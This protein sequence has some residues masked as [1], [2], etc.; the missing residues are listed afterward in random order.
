MD[1][2][3]DKKKYINRLNEGEIKAQF[4]YCLNEINY[5]LA[6]YEEKAKKLV[7]LSRDH[8]NFLRRQITQDGHAKKV[9]GP[10]FNL[11]S[12]MANVNENMFM[13]APLPLNLR[14]ISTVN[15]RYPIGMITGIGL[16]EELDG[17]KVHKR[18]GSWLVGV[19]SEISS[20]RFGR[21]MLNK[22]I[23]CSRRSE[24][25]LSEFE[26][27]VSRYGRVLVLR[28]DLFYLDKENSIGRMSP[29][30]ER[31]RRNIMHNKSLSKG[32]IK[33]FVKLEYGVLKGAHAHLIMLYDGSKRWRDDVVGDR[34]GRYWADVI[35][36]GEGW[37]FNA[38]RQSCKSRLSKSI[39]VP[40][41]LLAIGRH[42]R[43]DNTKLGNLVTLIGYLAK[44]DQ[45]LISEFGGNSR[46]FRIFSNGSKR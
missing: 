34:V 17:V 10:H 28:L 30:I 16:N 2:K 31:L 14:A 35:T 3:I 32:F 21:L 15:G 27:S 24:R 23:N 29:D 25:M 39:G 41:E 45:R 5:S 6:I 38:N 42:R 18:I 4:N 20:K 11:L 46:S 7:D 8:R 19:R 13:G 12:E 22:K 9:K 37:F 43:G 44:D 40:V 36:G 26:E 33:A 1:E